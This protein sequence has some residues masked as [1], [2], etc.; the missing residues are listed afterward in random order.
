MPVVSEVGLKLAPGG[1]V[2]HGIA[3]FADAFDEPGEDAPHMFL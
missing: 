2:L 1:N 3:K